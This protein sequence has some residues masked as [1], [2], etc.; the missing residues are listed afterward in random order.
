MKIIQIIQFQ[1]FIYL[2]II[3]KNFQN[4]KIIMVSNANLRQ[5]NQ[6]SKMVNFL[7]NIYDKTLHASTDD[8]RNAFLFVNTESFDLQIL[9][10][11][12]FECGMRNSHCRQS[13]IFKLFENIF[14]TLYFDI[15]HKFQSKFLQCLRIS[16]CKFIKLDLF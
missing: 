8:C 14:A 3:D 1:I 10:S 15:Y 11:P 16:I 6:T 7:D 9:H 12:A 2:I 5:I 13:Q 4:L